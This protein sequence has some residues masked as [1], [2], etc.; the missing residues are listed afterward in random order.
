MMMVRRSKGLSERHQKI[1]DLLRK[2]AERGYPPSIRE[3]GE[4]CG[5]SS[6]S[7]VNYYLNQLKDWG[8]IERNEKISRSIR[9]ADHTQ[10]AASPLQQAATAVSK[11]G[12]GL[13]QTVVEAGEAISQMLRIPVVTAIGASPLTPGGQEF[14]DPEST[15]EI[16][17]SMIGTKN[18]SDLFALE[19]RGNSMIDAMVNDGDYV[20]MKHENHPD[21][22][23][24]GEMVAIYMQETQETTLKNFFREKDGSF[25]LQPANPTMQPIFIPKGTPFQIQGKVVMIVR[26]FPTV[27]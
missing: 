23:R 21:L 6:T 16:A 15:L 19:V 27:H 3:I 13:R 24:N 12:Q 4:E 18:T 17:R 8:Y 26:K 25:R 11:A 20:I 1:M 7:V 14:A 2:S 22:I 10:M 9:I 5:I